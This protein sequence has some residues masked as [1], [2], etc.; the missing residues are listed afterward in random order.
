VLVA[1]GKWFKLRRET[2]GE[3]RGIRKNRKLSARGVNKIGSG[4]SLKNRNLGEEVTQIVSPTL[5]EKGENP[6]R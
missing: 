4:F 3:K 5:R 2:S 1:G 6:S